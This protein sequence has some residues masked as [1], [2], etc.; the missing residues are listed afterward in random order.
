M[1]VVSGDAVVRF[2]FGR[3]VPS[4]FGFDREL[5]AGGGGASGGQAREVIFVSS[6]R[7]GL[8]VCTE[9]AAI[10]YNQSDCAYRLY[11]DRFVL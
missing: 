11:F 6:R 3:G 8:S 1:V 9:Q 10:C 5:G 7:L 2:P 4:A